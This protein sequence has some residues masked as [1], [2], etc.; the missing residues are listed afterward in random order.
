MKLMYV[1]RH[2]ISTAANYNVDSLDMVFDPTKATRRQQDVEKARQDTR[3]YEDKLSQGSLPKYNV[4]PPPLN[5]RTTPLSRLCL[6]YYCLSKKSTHYWGNFINSKMLWRYCC[7]IQRNLR[8]DRLG[9]ELQSSLWATL[10]LTTP[11]LWRL[12]RYHTTSWR[13]WLLDHFKYWG[14]SNKIV[15]RSSF[16]GW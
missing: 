1:K 3:K 9:Q 7:P 14:N 8:E 10:V 13:I 11:L 6:Q 12:G 16:Q 15:K 4:L 5:H 2:Y